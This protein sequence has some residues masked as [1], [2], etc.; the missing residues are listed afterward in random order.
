MARSPGRSSCARTSW[1][2]TSACTRSS[3]DA[4]ADHAGDGPRCHGIRDRRGARAD[5]LHGRRQRLRAAER[6]RCEDAEANRPSRAAR[7]REPA[8]RRACRGTGASRRYAIDGARL[9]PIVGDARL[10]DEEARD[11]AR[12]GDAR[13][14]R[15]E[16]RAGD[17][18]DVSGARRDEDPDVR[19]PARQ[20]A[21]SRA[22]S[23]VVLRRGRAGF[24]SGARRCTSTRGSWS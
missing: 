20:P 17:A 18:R 5:L 15:L 6:A 19:A 9:A 3:A 1:A 11:V 8:H 24:E 21:R 10:E 23:I 16:V 2:T 14:R 4:D 7:E 13:D 22:R 12:T